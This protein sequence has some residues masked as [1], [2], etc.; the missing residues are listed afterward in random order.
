MGSP[1]AITSAGFNTAQGVESIFGAPTGSN[2]A[3]YAIT[4]KISG[5][6]GTGIGALGA[7]A[8]ATHSA[9]LAAFSA[10]AG[11]AL[12]GFGIALF[13]AALIFKGANPYQKPAAKVQQV[14]DLV[15]KAAYRLALNGYIT[16]G[17]SVALQQALKDLMFQT[18]AKLQAQAPNNQDLKKAIDAG[19][20]FEGA[21]MD[22]KIAATKGIADQPLKAFTLASIHAAKDEV[23]N[24]N[25][26]VIPRQ[27][28][29]GQKLYDDCVA[30]AS[31]VIDMYLTQYLQ[32][33]NGQ[34]SEGSATAAAGSTAT[35]PAGSVKPKLAYAGVAIALVLGALKLIL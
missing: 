9:A 7:L 27:G 2:Q 16:A 3:A 24:Q 20:S 14:F 28:D 35:T 30:Q 5:L 4:G 21:I 34:G 17:E 11:I 13:V 33:R 31:Q 10:T 12:L 8:A 22:Q 26:Y 6:A 18:W 23:Q 32:A 1:V 15:A 25:R 29:F 19:K